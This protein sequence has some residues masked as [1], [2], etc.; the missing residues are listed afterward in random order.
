[1]EN[2]FVLPKDQYTRDLN[3][4]KGFYD[5]NTFFL[6]R[7][8]AQPEQNVKAFLNKTLSRNGTY[9]LTDPTMMI[10]RQDSPGNRV[11]DEM[12]LLDYIGTVTDTNRILSPSMVCYENPK[13]LKSPSAKF[14]ESG[15]AGRKKAKN[16][17]FFAKVAGDEVLEKIKDAEQNAKKIAINSLSGM[18]GFA[19]N[20]LFVKS[21]HS[22][23]TSMCRSATGYGNASNERL[24]AGSR[25]YATPTIAVAN[26]SAL[27]TSQ[28]HVTYER[29]MTNCGLVYPDVQQTINCIRRSTDL[30]WRNEAKFAQ[31]EKFIS[32]MTPLERAIIVYTGDLYHIAQ[33]NDAYVRGFMDKVVKYNPD[34]DNTEFDDP[35]EFLKG[36]SVDDDTKILATY[37]NADITRG[38]NFESLKEKGLNDVLTKVARTAVNVQNV[39]QEYFE[40]IRTF[41]T[42][43]QLCPSVANIKGILRR[44]VL[45]SDTDSTIFTTQ[46]WVEWYT[47]D[48]NRTREGDG[49]WYTTTY[50]ACQ[51][52][53][54]VLAK[55]SA[56]M[57]VIPEDLHRLTMKNEYAFPVFTLTSRAKHYFAFMSC[58]EGNVFSEYDMEIKGVALRSSTVPVTII[59]SAKAMMKEVMYRADRN[60]QFSLEELYRKVWIHEQD[61]YT[62]IAKGE[63]KYLK[64]AQI[65]EAYPNM[66]KEDPFREKTNYRHYHFWETVFA[67][68]YGNVE[69]P[70]FSVIKVPLSINNKTDM[71]MWLTEAGKVNP[72][73]AERLKDYMVKSGRDMIKTL[74]LPLSI[75]SGIGMPKEVMPMINVRRLTYEIL[76]SFYMI[77]ES[78]GI[79]Q[80]DGN[81][82]R[83][84]SDIYE[85]PGELNLQPEA[86]DFNSL[87]EVDEEID[88]LIDEDSE[89]STWD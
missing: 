23:L 2:P 44:V 12:T 28:C 47:H 48:N 38:E 20:I 76:E 32:N 80:V 81:Y 9:P 4:V 67:P 83:L 14:V 82:V 64:S 74:Y 21:G 30:Y 11:K 69:S 55:L 71:Q 49:I 85:P 56:N 57:G 37:L 7:M 3:L 70:P 41:L 53:I 84:V 5:Q 86:M 16:E 15:I 35:F 6:K 29:A 22:S 75:L 46:E 62:S 72:E 31:I 78:L 87:I 8:T 60:E 66:N 79:F 39:M 33:L 19:G 25:H 68:T 52:I 45:A 51:C 36:K 58:R 65:Q 26:M 13:V 10:L 50:I 42:P 40:F 88:D 63:H 18:H 34:H 59:K 61:I 27:V 73:F 54:H 77:L 24:L 1:M 89:E 43:T 17:M